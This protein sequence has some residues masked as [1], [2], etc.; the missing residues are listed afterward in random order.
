MLTADPNDGVSNEEARCFLE[1]APPR[2]A[3]WRAT[4]ASGPR[5]D[6]QPSTARFVV[7][8]RRMALPRLR[9]GL[10]QPPRP[11]KHRGGAPVGGNVCPRPRSCSFAS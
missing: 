4:H 7:A 10:H 11:S 5:P 6:S 9:S 1:P 8:I 3:S 2:S